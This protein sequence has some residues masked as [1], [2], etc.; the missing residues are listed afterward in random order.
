MTTFNENKKL[1]VDLLSQKNLNL[2][3]QNKKYLMRIMNKGQTVD[4]S[5]KQN[6][7]DQTALVVRKRGGLKNSYSPKG[8]S[9]LNSLENENFSDI[10]NI[11]PVQSDQKADEN[12]FSEKD[13]EIDLGK[14]LKKPDL[15]DDPAK[16]L[17][18]HKYTDHM[19]SIKWSS[20]SGWDKPKIG[21]I[22]NLELH[23]GAKCLHYSVQL[24]EGMK[25]FRGVDHKIRLFRPNLNFNRMHKSIFICF[26]F[27]NFYY[28]RYLKF[29]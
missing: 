16:L 11:K 25:A 12:C 27:L 22:Q 29:L 8:Y 17:F 14:D 24:F 18:G 26:F 10:S 3:E 1:L 9:F 23:P 2:S 5:S 28:N 15:P 19:L 6:P 21:V 20:K 7:T 4:D 13:L